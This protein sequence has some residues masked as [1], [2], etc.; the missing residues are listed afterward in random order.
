MFGWT[1]NAESKA[2]MAGQALQFQTPDGVFSLQRAHSPSPSHEPGHEPTGEPRLLDVCLLP[3]SSAG[4]CL[5]SHSASCTFHGTN[6]PGNVERMGQSGYQLYLTE[7]M[8]NVGR[9]FPWHEPRGYCRHKQYVVKGFF[10]ARYWCRRYSR[11]RARWR[12]RTD[13]K[14]ICMETY[15][16]AGYVVN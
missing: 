4:Q 7:T 15:S 6:H 2:Y 10:E 8:Q 12:D 1:D 5:V 14:T 13:R 9:R 3:L 11:D 16:S